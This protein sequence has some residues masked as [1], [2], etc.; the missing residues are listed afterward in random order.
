MPYSAIQPKQI[1]KRAPSQREYEFLQEWAPETLKNHEIPS[2][3]NTF[4]PHQAAPTSAQGM[5]NPRQQ[6][7]RTSSLY[8]D[9]KAQATS[10]GE[11]VHKECNPSVHTPTQNKN[12][13]SQSASFKSTAVAAEKPHDNLQSKTNTKSSQPASSKSNT[14]QS[15]HFAQ[16]TVSASNRFNTVHASNR[17]PSKPVADPIKVAQEPQQNP[18]LSASSPTASEATRSVESC[19]GKP[20][21]VRQKHDHVA[22]RHSSATTASKSL[23][24]AQYKP[25]EVKQKHRS[26]SSESAPMSPKP[27]ASS[28][29][30]DENKQKKASDVSV[31]ITVQ[32]SKPVETSRKPI[33]SRQKPRGG[34][35]CYT[36]PNGTRFP[37]HNDLHKW[38]MGV[39]NQHND[40]IIFM[41]V[42]VENPWKGLQPVL[43][44]CEFRF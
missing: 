15:Y 19:K 29:S 1:L 18:R 14:L 27:A 43:T 44:T 40:L 20:A 16:P 22:S 35:I 41:P 11:N 33:E 17:K 32:S 7:L 31:P 28:K 37:R 24:S 8:E 25:T 42:F 21:E 30:V 34:S 3:Q 5:S 38:S 9:W 36:A 23:D 4:Q 12:H 26:G 10:Q 39:K 6:K 13:Q 2:Q